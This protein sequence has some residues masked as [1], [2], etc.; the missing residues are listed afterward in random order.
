[1]VTRIIDLIGHSEK[2][3]SLSSFCAPYQ[4]TFPL[5]CFYQP[6]ITNAVRTH[7]LLARGE[8]N[9]FLPGEIGRDDSFIL[10]IFFGV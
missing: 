9:I 7:L 4:T 8:N 5:D 6:S 10:S 3:F 2:Y 1:M